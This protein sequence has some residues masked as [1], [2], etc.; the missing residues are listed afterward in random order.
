MPAHATT[1]VLATLELLQT[2]G[3]LSGAEL[4][5]RV[6]V[7]RRTVRRYITW[8]EELGVPVTTVR[9]PLGGYELLAGFKLPPLMFTNDEALALG[10]GLAAVQ[11]L[12]LGAG[13][14]AIAGAQAKLERVMPANLRNR[15]RA[16]SESVAFHQF[17][18]MSAG[19]SE[20]LSLLSAAA[21]QNQ[22]V[23]L[24]YQ[25]PAGQESARDFDPYGLACRDGR[26]YVAGYCH[27]RKALRSFRLDRVTAV[28]PQNRRFERPGGFDV[29]AH[30][31]SSL[32]TLPRKFTIQVKLATDLNSARRELFEALGVLEP[33]ADGG[34]MLHAQADD[35]AWFA[36]E[37]ARLPWPFQII[38]PAALR[39]A[40]R[41]HSRVLQT[42]VAD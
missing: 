11:G 32:A 7:D 31:T 39:R 37:L 6:G 24:R 2:H 27:L 10:L 23:H 8:L 18:H 19:A 9:G 3:R 1:R 36:R 21:H 20:A 4:A 35:L 40:L 16:V 41:A 28:E 25:T 42:A 5:R 26:W 38:R 34:T 14:P 33:A 17:R 30:L 12:G 15:M 13:T 29:L 22:G